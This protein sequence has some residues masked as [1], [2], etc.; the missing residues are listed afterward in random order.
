[1]RRIICGVML[2]S[3]PAGA[4]C[5]SRAEPPPP[6][7]SAAKPT[8]TLAQVMRGIYFPNA[9]LL[10]DVQQKDPGAPAQSGDGPRGS[11]TEQFSSIYTGW[12]V[13]E[14]AAVALAESTDLITVPGRACQNGKPVPVERPEYTKAAQGM[15]QAALV[16][17]EAARAKNREQAIDAT[18]TIADGCAAC[19][20]KYRDVG[21]ADGPERCT[22]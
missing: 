2:L 1:M 13:I 17:L 20:E 10:F 16:A 14:N 19:H 15:R 6:A 9:N 11:V 3:I 21:E 4:A 5:T 8:G 12:Q 7:A 22:P 18:N